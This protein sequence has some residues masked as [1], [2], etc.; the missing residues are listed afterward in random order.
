MADDGLTVGEL[1]ATGW[2]RFLSIKLSTHLFAGI[3]TAALATYYADP[4]LQ[5]IVKTFL[6]RHPDIAVSFAAGVVFWRN[7]TK[8]MRG[9]TVTVQPGEN[10]VGAIAVKE[11]AK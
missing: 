8:V 4:T 5:T 1:F 11:D 6:V 10:A 7:Y 3:T 9:T 2:Q